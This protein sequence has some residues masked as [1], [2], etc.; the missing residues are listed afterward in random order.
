MKRAILMARVSSDDQAKGYSLDEQQDV[1]LKYCERNSI[2]VIQVYREDHSAKDFERPEFKKIMSFIKANPGL[3]NMLL[4]ISWDRFSRNV[5]ESYNVIRTLQRLKI[6]PQA[7]TQ[8]IDHSIPEQKLLLAFYLSMPEVDNDIRSN[9]TKM[10]IRG[11]RKAGRLV[12]K[13]PKG[14]KNTRDEYNKPIIIPSNDAKHIQYAF[15]QINNGLS[16]SEI[17]KNLIQKGYYLSKNGLSTLLRNK[18]YAGK[19]HVPED[20]DNAPY[21]T[22]GL[23]DALVTD[24]Q[25]ETVQAILSN[26]KIK[27]KRAISIR[28]RDELPLRGFLLCTKCSHISTGSAS[29]SRNG[30]RYFYYHC[31]NCKSERFRA[32]IVDK[33]MSDIFDEFKFSEE[34]QKL[35]IAVAKENFQKANFDNSNE[36]MLLREQLKTQLK[37]LT[38]LQEMLVDGKITSSDYHEMRNRFEKEKTKIE[39]QLK[40]MTASNTQFEKFLESGTKIFYDLKKFYE[41]TTIDVKQ[42]IIG[43]TFPEKLQF[44]KNKVRTTLINE[45]LSRILLF[46]NDLQK[47]KTGTKFKNLILSPLVPGTG[48]E[49]AHP[50]G[51]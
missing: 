39:Q 12:G 35:F 26:K 47:N 16:Q 33:A 24:E 45:L 32:D 46:G 20:K 10:G 29:R 44:Y 13:A 30:Q 22:K 1:L 28:K 17:R 6:N 25:F 49:P 37:R 42:L 7:I 40:E 21:Y 15:E 5:T 2:E 43:S 3:V 9:K 34:I 23:H 41:E 38:N 27:S 8:P 4:F 48:L 36:K 50:C 14:Y 51:H 31:N 18:I 11:A 19:I